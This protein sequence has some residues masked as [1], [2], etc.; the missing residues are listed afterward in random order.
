MPP[1]LPISLGANPALLHNAQRFGLAALQASLVTLPEPTDA[2]KPK[3]Y[4][5]RN[6]NPSPP[7]PA[8]PTAP[9]SHPHA[10]DSPALFDRLDVDTLFFVFYYQQNTYAQYLAARALK[11]H[12]WRF[13]K[14]YMTWFQR[15]E[16]P[17][18]VTEDY[19]QGESMA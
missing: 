16:E 11:A 1:S 17:K 10:M 9:P 4:V 5:P 15:H 14:K 8:F 18:A 19:E 6:P 13:H 3:P 12:A 2:D 7:H